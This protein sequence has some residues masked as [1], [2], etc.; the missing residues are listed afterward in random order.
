MKPVTVLSAA[1]QVAEHLRAELLR[2]GFGKTMPGVPTLMAELGVSQKTVMAALRILEKEGLLE[3]QGQGLQRRIVPPKGGVKASSLRVAL[4]VFDAVD[5]GVD[6]MLELRHQLEMAGHVPFYPDK[7]LLDL[8][9]DDGRV[10]HFV[11]RTKADAWVV[12]AGSRGVLEW[13]AEQETPAL[14]LAGIASGLPIA[15]VVPDKAAVFADLT[16]RL[17]ALGH[18]RITFLC[19]GQL[20]LPQPARTTSAF[21]DALKAAGI[22]IG[23]FNLPDWEE[24]KEGFERILE[25]LFGHTP[26]TALIPDEPLLYH[27][28]V[29]FL[30]KRRLRVPEDVSLICTDAD[31][32]FAWC[33][34]S[35]SHIRWDYR[36]VV[37]RIVRWA[38]NVAKGKDDRRQTRTKAEFVEAGTV[39]PAP[40]VKGR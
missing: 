20:R 35:V 13:F 19:R 27:A 21:L 39:G 33:N 11:G 22:A 23:T 15:S 17:V 4:L 12:L 14:A 30:M 32:G 7:S 25:S 16:R 38:N 29:Q 28:A 18:N 3:N 6:Y 26:P 2:G 1:Q 36:P 8:G 24:S 34:P 10:A 9:M 37:H 40:V 5:R 31:P